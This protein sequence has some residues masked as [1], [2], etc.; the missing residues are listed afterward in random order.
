MEL[1]EEN[2]KLKEE[3]EKLKKEIEEKGEDDCTISVSIGA[4]V[5]FFA[6]AISFAICIV[7]QDP[8]DKKVFATGV[9][10]F[11][12]LTIILIIGLANEKGKSKIYK[13]KNKSYYGNA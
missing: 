2:D 5:S 8:W 10:I 9:F 4:L 13:F 7:S 3:L 6:C 11:A 1:K 12:V